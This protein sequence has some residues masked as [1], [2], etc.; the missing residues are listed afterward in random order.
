MRTIIDLN[1]LQLNIKTVDEFSAVKG[2]TNTALDFVKSYIS[3]LRH[4]N[5]RKVRSER[6]ESMAKVI[7]VLY[8]YL[9]LNPFSESYG[10]CSPS[11]RTIARAIDPSLQTVCETDSEIV[12]RRKEKALHKVVMYVQRSIQMLKEFGIIKTHEYRA[13]TNQDVD[14]NPNFYYEI[15]PVSFL[16]PK[17]KKLLKKFVNTAIRAYDVIRDI[18]D[19]LTDEMMLPKKEKDLKLS[20]VLLI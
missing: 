4:S 15:I 18:L 5:G 9:N 11:M 1:K 6:K 7:E 8:R 3:N 16:C 10:E 19:T 17:F 12:K 13:E 20:E 2:G 14:R